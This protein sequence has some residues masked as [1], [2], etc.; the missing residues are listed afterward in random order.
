MKGWRNSP[1]LLV[2]PHVSV[3]VHVLAQYLPTYLTGSDLQ[4]QIIHVIRYLPFFAEL[5]AVKMHVA[6]LVQR[7]LGCCDGCNRIRNGRTALPSASVEKEKEV[8]FSP[9]GSMR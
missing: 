8:S 3:H 7:L 5:A 4:R 2:P 6:A 9:K 1:T